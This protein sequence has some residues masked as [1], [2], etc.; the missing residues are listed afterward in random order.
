M[1]IIVTKILKVILCAWCDLNFSFYLE[2]Y[3]TISIILL[4]LSIIII[5]Y[6]NGDWLLD[7]SGFC[8]ITSCLA[9]ELHAIFHSLHIAYDA[10]YMNIILG[11]NSRTT[12]DLIM[13]DAQPHHPYGHLIS[14]I[15]QLH[16]WNWIVI[17]HHTLYQGNKCADWLAKHNAS[18]SDVLK[19]WIFC[20][21]QLHHSL[22]DDA[23]GGAHIRL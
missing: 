14:Q 23:L 3:N 13:L 2:K 22:L 9:A 20:P 21:H 18:S 10:G 15:V 12:L 8:G 4:D 17:F 5:R 6:K 19:S 11:S 7:F 16:H 1:C